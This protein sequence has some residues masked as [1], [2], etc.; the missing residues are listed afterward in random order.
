M[1]IFVTGE[2][3]LSLLLKMIVFDVSWVELFGFGD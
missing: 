2:V 1:F 3:G